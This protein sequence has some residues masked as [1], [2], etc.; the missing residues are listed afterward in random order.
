[1]FILSRLTCSQPRLVSLDLRTV[2]GDYVNEEIFHA[3]PS[4]RS[5]SFSKD[6]GDGN[7][8]LKKAI[9]VMS[10]TTTLHVHHA[11]LYGL[12]PS[13][14]DYD[15][16]MPDRKLYGGRKQWMTNVSFLFLN[17]SAVPK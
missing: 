9:G 2:A 14:H 12:L 3:P 7:E 6:D 8:D 4:L 17:L 15:L 13:L 10:K 5:G 16:K 11:F 1:M